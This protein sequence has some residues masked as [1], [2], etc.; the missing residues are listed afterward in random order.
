MAF[1]LSSPNMMIVWDLLGFGM[2]DISAPASWPIRAELEGR[3]VFEIAGGTTS[4]VK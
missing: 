3:C 2:T 4:S 1:G